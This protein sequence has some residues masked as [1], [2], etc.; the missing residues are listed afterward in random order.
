MTTDIMSEHIYC[1]EKINDTEDNYNNKKEKSNINIVSMD[2]KSD[3]IHNT[4]GANI[5]EILKDS[6]ILE[7]T[8]GAFSYG[9]IIKLINDLKNDSENHNIEY[10]KFLINSIGELPLRKKLEYM[11]RQNREKSYKLKDIL[12]EQIKIETDEEK[13]NK[14]KKILNGDQ[15]D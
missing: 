14:I 3:R 11:Y 1:L 10:E 15:D 8:I 5:Y 2:R 13:L 6:F 4:F 12:L 9:K 7:K